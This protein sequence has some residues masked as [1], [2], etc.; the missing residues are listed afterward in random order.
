M[1]FVFLAYTSRETLLP[2]TNGA[3]VSVDQKLMYPIQFQS[4]HVFLELSK[5]MFEGKMEINDDTKL[6]CFRPFWTRNRSD[7]CVATHCYGYHLN[8]F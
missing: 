2:V 8:T 5:S 7:R 4:H 6:T 1:C 3:L